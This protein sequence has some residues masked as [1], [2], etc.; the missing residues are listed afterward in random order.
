VE[1]AVAG[2][3]ALALYTVAMALHFYVAGHSLRE[4][5]GRA[6]ERGGR[7]VLAA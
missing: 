6:Y 1:R 2:G 3:L 7:W 4:E 5:H